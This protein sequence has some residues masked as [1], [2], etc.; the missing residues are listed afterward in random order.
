MYKTLGSIHSTEINKY[1]FYWQYLDLNS[2]LARQVLYHL[3]HT[4]ALSAF[5]IFK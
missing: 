2:G 1:L 3:S 4:P 5:I